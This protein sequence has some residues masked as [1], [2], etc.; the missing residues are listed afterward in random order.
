MCHF[1]RQAKVQRELDFDRDAGKYFD[2]SK[3][4]FFF[5]CGIVRGDSEL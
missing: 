4:F 2:S 3:F 5:I 1:V